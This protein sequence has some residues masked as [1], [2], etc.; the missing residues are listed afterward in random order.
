M[1]GLAPLLVSLQLPRDTFSTVDPK[2]LPELVR[3][4]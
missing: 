1:A 4:A 3:L 2:L